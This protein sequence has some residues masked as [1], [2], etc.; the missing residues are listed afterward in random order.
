MPYSAD[1]AA[2]VFAPG[3]GPAEPRKFC[4]DCGLSRTKEAGL[5]G[6]ACQFIRPDYPAMETR[7]Q[8]R[9]RDPDRGEEAFFGPYRAM[10]RARL[11]APRE[12]AQWTGITTRLA[13]RL[14]EDGA[15]D[16]VLTVAPDSEDRW[17]PVPVW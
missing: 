9:E 1:P 5:C 7:V 15:V 12:G 8:G 13:E 3:Y 17:R 11:K 16:A 6:Q 2:P 10:Y 14:L 4:T